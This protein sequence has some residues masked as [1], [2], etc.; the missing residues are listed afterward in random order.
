[1]DD[2]VDAVYVQGAG[3][4]QAAYTGSDDGDAREARGA[5]HESRDLCFLRGWGWWE[6]LWE[7]LRDP[8]RDR[9]R[10]A[11]DTPVRR[12]DRYSAS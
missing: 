12:S 8:D 10:E 11:Q 3:E 9:D 1:M 2:G 6:A 5:A 7:A 4:G